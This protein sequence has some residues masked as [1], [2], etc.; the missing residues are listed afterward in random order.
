M[1]QLGD[2]WPLTLVD[3]AELAIGGLEADSERGLAAVSFLLCVASAWN[4]AGRHHG[5]HVLVHGEK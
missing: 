1:L 4:T 3:V 5:H 2:P